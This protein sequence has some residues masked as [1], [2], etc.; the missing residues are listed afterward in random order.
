[1]NSNDLHDIEKNYFS[2]THSNFSKFLKNI[3]N[4]ELTN[5]TLKKIIIINKKMLEVNNLLE[6]INYN[7]NKKNPRLTVDIEKELKD[8]EDNDK[9]VKHFL[10]YIMYYRFLME[11]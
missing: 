4:K 9:A 3:K 2:N 1:M 6:D 7:I 8:Y 10:P 5:D 11:S